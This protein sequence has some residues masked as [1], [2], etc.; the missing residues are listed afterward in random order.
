M[1]R[2][3]YVPQAGGFIDFSDTASD[4]DIKSYIRAKYPK[5]QPVAAPAPEEAAATSDDS[6]VLGRFA[7]G[8]GTGITDVPGGIAALFYPS[9]EATKTSAGQISEQSRKYLQETFGIDPTKDPTT[10]QWLAETLG[11][12][13]SFLVPGGAVAKG[14][15]LAGKGAA[16]AGR[17]AALAGRAGTLTAAGQG[18]ALGLGE[19]RAHLVHEEEHE[20]AGPQD[21]RAHRHT[22]RFERPSQRPT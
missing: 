5:P 1:A 18:V 11:S 6:S 7:Y 13:A 17:G 12:A 8:L 21:V 3:I 4:E 15:A 9:E 22:T 14:A 16:L 10:A 19:R 2:A 20:P